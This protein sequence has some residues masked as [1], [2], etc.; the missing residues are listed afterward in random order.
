M[1]KGVTTTNITVENVN[2]PGYTWKVDNK[3]EA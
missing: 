1:A 3:Y 2:V